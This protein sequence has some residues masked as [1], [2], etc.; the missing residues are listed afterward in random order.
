MHLKEHINAHF[1]ICFISLVI[2]RL[3]EIRLKN[4][5]TIEKILDSLRSVSCSHMDTNHYLFDYADEVTDDINGAFNLDIGQKVM[6]LK[7]IKKIFANV[8]KR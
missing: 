2:A 8:K 3:V 1:F 7:E 4:K 5:Y 6:T